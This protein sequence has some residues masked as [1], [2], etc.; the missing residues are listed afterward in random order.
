MSNNYRAI[1]TALFSLSRGWCF[2]PTDNLCKFK[3]III[4]EIPESMMIL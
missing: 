4:P 1:L 3:P 2:S